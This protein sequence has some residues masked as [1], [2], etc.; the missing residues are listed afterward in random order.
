MLQT[1]LAVF[2][3]FA[4]II[5]VFVLLKLAGVLKTEAQ[6]EIKIPQN[7]TETF[8]KCINVLGHL[9]GIIK[10]Q[11][12]TSG[13]IKATIFSIPSMVI[14]GGVGISEV[15]IKLSKIDENNTGAIISSKPFSYYKYILVNDYRRNSKLVEQLISELT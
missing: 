6:K 9:K 7:F 10:E 11:N 1:V 12:A 15:E 2:S 13:L 4:L 5:I 3:F 8:Q 14:W